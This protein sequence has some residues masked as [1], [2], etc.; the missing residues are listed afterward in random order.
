MSLLSVRRRLLMDNICSV[1]FHLD[2][3]TTSAPNQVFKGMPYTATFSVLDDKTFIPS[4]VRVLMGGVEITKNVFNIETYVINIPKVTGNIDIT[5]EALNVSSTILDAYDIVPYITCVYKVSQPGIGLQYYPTEKTKIEFV[6]TFTGASPDYIH[7]QRSTMMSSGGVV[8]LGFGDV[9][10]VAYLCWG[11][12]KTEK[13]GFNFASLAN[14]ITDVTVDRGLF[15]VSCK[16]LRRHSIT[17]MHVD[18]E[19]FTGTQYLTLFGNTTSIADGSVYGYIYRYKHWEDDVLVGD[20]IPVRRKSDGRVG[21]YDIVGNAFRYGNS[22]YWLEPYIKV[23]NSYT[24]CTITRLSAALTGTS[25]VAVIGKSW[26]S[27]F[28]PIG[29]C[30]FNSQDAIFQVM[31]NNVDKT[32]DYATYDSTTDT[33]AVTL[34]PHWKDD[35]SITATPDGI[36]ELAFIGNSWTG[37]SRVENAIALEIQSSSKGF[38]VIQNGS[39]VSYPL[40]D[41]TVVKY[42]GVYYTTLSNIYL[43]PY[44]GLQDL[45]VTWENNGYVLTNGVMSV[46]SDTY[47]KHCVINAHAGE[48]YYFI[49]FGAAGTTEIIKEVNGVYTSVADIGTT[50]GIYKKLVIDEDCTLYVSHYLQSNKYTHPVVAIGT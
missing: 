16:S 46:A 41:G 13:G 14:E 49:L 1:T 5:A 38:Y 39:T 29:N 3:L 2:G 9:S 23:T 8:Y 24:N 20:L 11:G 40:A 34:V 35:I 30:T 25:T 22:D 28:T 19:T 44:S 4:S 50:A 15:D 31:V 47:F 10:K 37:S 26:S 45:E 27:K 43:V 33:W 7:I 17:D 21:L 48:T 6:Y 12:R 18:G 42:D 36:I 32:I